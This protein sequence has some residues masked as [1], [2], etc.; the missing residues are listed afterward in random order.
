[1]STEVANI[2][3]GEIIPITSEAERLEVA[4]IRSAV[5][6][7][8]KLRNDVM[9]ENI[10]YG[11]IPGTKKPSL[12]KAGAEKL[13]FA[14]QMVGTFETTSKDEDY[15]REWEYR[16]E[17]KVWDQSSRR[18]EITGQTVKAV[19][20][21]YAYTVRCTVKSRIT[22]RVMGECLGTC[23]SLE[24]GRE[25]APA[26]TILKMAQK[27]AYVGAV[28]NATFSSDRFTQDME[29]FRFDE[30][31][32]P[33]QEVKP[34]VPSPQPAREP[35]NIIARLEAGEKRLLADKVVTEADILDARLAYL[36]DKK[37]NKST[38]PLEF[39]ESSEE[40]CWRYFEGFVA[41]SYRE[42]NHVHSA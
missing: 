33:K 38:T 4:A 27:R 13:A 16:S 34:V 3:T 2:E 28:L 1:M 19:Q 29:D 35:I 42:A 37:G 18:Y 26:N 30:K 7:V 15:F 21:F 11:V 22:G 9:I 8:D 23:N 5:E 25:S 41:A 20:G 24:R 17:T 40:S 14:F 10:D 12:Y 6:Y 31:S 32:E 36:R 39:D